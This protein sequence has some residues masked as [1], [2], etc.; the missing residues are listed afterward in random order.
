MGY[1]VNQNIKLSAFV[2]TQEPISSQ[3]NFQS[4]T[5]FGYSNND[6]YIGITAVA[7]QMYSNWQN[8]KDI[9]YTFSKT[10]FTLA[11]RLHTKPLLSEK[12][13]FWK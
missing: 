5:A 3:A 9:N 6:F 11:K 8:K 12:P 13:D 10:K 4:S 2:G 7:D 1:V